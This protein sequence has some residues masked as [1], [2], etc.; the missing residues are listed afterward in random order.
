MK[1]NK[2][3]FVV[4]FCVGAQSGVI[5][6]SE[7][8]GEQAPQTQSWREWAGSYM[9]SAKA[10]AQAAAAAAKKR[11]QQ[12]AGAVMSY[13]GERWSAIKKRTEVDSP[14]AVATTA[15]ALS[16]QQGALM[17]VIYTLEAQMGTALIPSDTSVAYLTEMFGGVANGGLVNVGISL[18]VPTFLLSY[19][20]QKVF[21]YYHNKDITRQ[22]AVSQIKDLIF[23]K[24][25]DSLTYP[26]R[27]T[28]LHALLKKNEF[29]VGVED[30]DGLFAQ[31]CSDLSKQLA[32]I[33]YSLAERKKDNAI[34]RQLSLLRTQLVNITSLDS[35]LAKISTEDITNVLNQLED[36]EIQA[37]L[38]L[39]RRLQQQKLVEEYVPG[40]LKQTS[41]SKFYQPM[42]KK[43]EGS[44][45][46]RKKAWETG[47]KEARKMT[48]EW[49][50]QK[51]EFVQ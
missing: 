47:M 43:E 37:K 25:A 22:A 50:K 41:S 3:L 21:E 51:E 5:F 16:A 8:E 19:G 26:T 46:D 40:T 2:I 36:P 48:T 31:A 4:F 35:Q 11:A 24:L 28:K 1:I 20:M 42:T 12:A 14:L 7:V 17:G 30:A 44:F 38:S 27:S 49:G 23:L 45:E 6:G 13:S 18:A 33:P 9:T 39:V 10:K 32:A 34:D 15:A 29:L